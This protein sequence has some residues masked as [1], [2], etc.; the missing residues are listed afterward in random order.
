MKNKMKLI[1]KSSLIVGIPLLAVSTNA[2]LKQARDNYYKEQRIK[3]ELEKAQQKAQ[4]EQE[5]AQQRAQKEKL[6]AQ[7][8]EQMESNKKDIKIV[9]NKPEK[10]KDVAPKVQKKMTSQE[11][12]NEKVKQVIANVRKEVK[13][14]VAYEPVSNVV[15]KS[16]LTAKDRAR[17]RK[18][19]K[20]IRAEYFAK[21]KSQKLKNNETLI[22]K[23]SNEGI[24]TKKYSNAE[25]QKVLKEIR[26][27]YKK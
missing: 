26:A 14:V 21:N 3:M 6:A 10:Q 22:V 1:L 15:A 12:D 2:I 19:L 7:E 11:K 4:R 17:A 24:E 5:L 20:E 18:A 27:N 13:P 23:T 16:E 9:D 25:I 8:R